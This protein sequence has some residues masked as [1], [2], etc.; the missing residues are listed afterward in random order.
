MDTATRRNAQLSLVVDRSGSMAEEGR[1][2]YLRRGLLQL[3]DQLKTGDIVHVTI[4]DH[5]VCVP[6][7]NFVVGRDDMGVLR[8]TIERLRPRARPICTPASPAA[9]A[10]GSR[11]PA[12]LY[13][14]RGDDHRPLANTGETDERLNATIAS[15][16]D[17]RKIRLSGVGV[18]ARVQRCAP[19]PLTERGRG[20]YV[21]LGSE[22][23]VDAVFG[24]RFVSLIETTA[25][26]VH[27]RLHLPPSLRMNVFYGEESS[28]HKEDGRRSTTSPT[29]RSSSSRSDGAGRTRARSDQIMLTIEYED[30]ETGRAQEGNTPSPSGT[31]GPASATSRRG[32]C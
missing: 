24:S 3:T 22:A 9:R 13:Q 2:D 19:R 29:P 12:H 27:F 14:P 10:R 21:F 23:E 8:R 25:E 11:L 16:T 6:I 26:D 4:F 17:A 1:M 31:S 30:P 15:T 7:Q 20:A 18:G 28:V 32:A 5:R